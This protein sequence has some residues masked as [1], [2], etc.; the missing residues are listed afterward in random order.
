MSLNNLLFEG[1]VRTYYLKNKFFFL[2]KEIYVWRIVSED[3]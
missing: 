3:S 2:R 1:Q